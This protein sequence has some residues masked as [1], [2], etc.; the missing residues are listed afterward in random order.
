MSDFFTHFGYEPFPLSISIT[1]DIWESYFAIRPDHK[2]KFA[3]QQMPS[4]NGTV[5][6]PL[7]LDGIYTVLIY[8]EYI[9]DDIQKGCTAWIGTIIHE[10]CHA[11][12]YIEYAKLINAKSFDDVLDTSK[13]RMFQIWTE[14]NARR[15]GYF[16]LRKY[17]FDDIGD[18]IQLPDIINT[19]IP[20]QIDYMTKEYSS[21][22]DGWSQIYVVTQF[23]GRL[24]VWKELFPHY[25]TSEKVMELFNNNFWMND[26]FDFLDGYRDLS[27]ALF[28]FD[29]LMEILRRNFQGL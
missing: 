22:I 19:E 15:H 6:P 20:F 25:F 5:V 29:E 10:A 21:T 26:M 1:N 17:A 14:F 23:M 16:F 3:G 27:L 7:K 4:F 28:H 11:R 9:T 2:S 13:H 12:D 24:A 8:Q 18:E